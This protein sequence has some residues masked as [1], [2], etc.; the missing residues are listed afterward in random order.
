MLSPA[1]KKLLVLQDRDMRRL[2]L[3]AQLKA[4]PGEAA[5]E[6]R[7]IAA[8]RNAIEAGKNELKDLE[9]KK[10]ALETEIGSAE[11]KVGKYRTQQLAVRKNDEFQA[12]GHEI[13]TTVAQIGD[14][15]GR[16]LEIMYAIDEAR[17]RFAAGEAAHKADIAAREA[18]IRSLKEREES[19]AVELR[20]AQ[21]AAASVRVPLPPAALEAYDRAGRKGMPAVVPLRD[22]KCGG[23]HLKVSSEVESA[24]RGK[25]PNAEF[26]V[27]DQCGRIVYWEG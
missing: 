2:G 22:N 19:L 13:D 23:C 27:C 11:Q 9:V 15:E 14:L 10:K 18:R 8:A 12:L 6:E 26:A 5:L 1:L 20:A 17:K 25:D 21:E 4:M 16:E 3:E 7:R 24:A